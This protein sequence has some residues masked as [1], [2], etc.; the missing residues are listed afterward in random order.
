MSTEV[1]IPRLG[2]S[3]QS[4]TLTEWLVPDGAEVA[5]GQPI[6][7]LES[8]KST[9]EVEAPASGRLIQKAAPGDSDLPVGTVIGEIG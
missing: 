7:L 6:F 9:I 1:I 3:M 4:G 2:M 8:D 5:L